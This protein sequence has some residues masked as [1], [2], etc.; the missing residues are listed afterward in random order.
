MAKGAQLGKND[1]S[2]ASVIG[3][4]SDLRYYRLV[5]FINKSLQF[6]LERFN[7]L[8]VVY[9]AVESPISYPLFFWYDLD[10]RISFSMLG[11]SSNGLP[12][13]RSV[14]N[15]DF[16]LI[17]TGSHD[18]YNLNGVI[19][20][21][22]S[23]DGV[24]LAQSLSSRSLTGFERLMQQLEMHLMTEIPENKMLWSYI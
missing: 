24:R 21:I 1:E 9:P 11:N 23:I 19:S 7:D 22:R 8:K 4:V 13:I 18:R 2:D 20:T 3:L 17:S 15:I 10:N 16:L 14:R 12:L 5:H 6:R